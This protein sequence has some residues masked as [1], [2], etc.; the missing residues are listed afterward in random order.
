MG[1]LD[2]LGQGAQSFADNFMK[3]YLGL[4]QNRRAQQEMAMMEKYRQQQ[5]DKMK[6]ETDQRTAEAANMEAFRK[7]SRGPEIMGMMGDGGPQSTPGAFQ[8]DPSLNIQRGTGQYQGLPLAERARLFSERFP[9]EGLKNE[10]ALSKTQ[11][12]PRQLKVIYGPEGQT[13]MTVISGDTDLPLG[14]SFEKPEKQAPTHLQQGKET[15]HDTTTGITFERSF[16]FN[17]SDGKRADFSEW[18]PTKQ[19]K[20]PAD[21]S[22]KIDYE[23]AKTLIRTLPKLKEDATIAAQSVKT[24]QTMV[25]LIG[26]GSAGAIGRLKGVLAPYAEA[27]GYNSKSM[28]DAQ[29]YQ[30]LAKTISGSMRMA[31]VGPGQVSNYE[32]QLLQSISG[33]GTTATAAAKALLEHYAAQAQ[34]KVE[35][36]NRDRDQLNEV[37]PKGGKMFPRITV[38]SGDR[39]GQAGGR[40]PLDSFKR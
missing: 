15:K 29:T 28:S 20:Q 27:L 2:N 37:S 35:S 8:V 22:L 36:Y 16:T 40:P 5:E 26:S 34:A 17:P 10:I 30:L 6:A 32:T 21:P 38:P 13:K 14:W 19:E 23:A 39:T 9:K 31:I 11:D 24:M 33:G 1:F 25:D 4:Q 7:E 3:T 18:T 12:T